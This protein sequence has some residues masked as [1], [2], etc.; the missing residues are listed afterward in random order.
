M[1]LPPSLRNIFT[2][3]ILKAVNFL[4]L[5][6]PVPC[7]KDPQDR[8]KFLRLGPF[9]FVKP[10][11]AIFNQAVEVADLV[12]G[13]IIHITLEQQAAFT[14]QIIRCK[15]INLVQHCSIKEEL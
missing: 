12:V 4:E 9:V 13:A 10:S 7:D 14:E 5:I 8:T 1:T 15:S 11:P 2:A 3:K 6:K